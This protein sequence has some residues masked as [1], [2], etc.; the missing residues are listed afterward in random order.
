MTEKKKADTKKTTTKKVAPAK[1]TTATKKTETKKAEPKTTKPA[2]SK[3][4]V[5]DR[6]E[7]IACR[8][9]TD[10][11][12]IYISDRT[13]ARY[14]WS[15]FGVAQYIDMGELLD[16]RA[17]QPKFLNNVQLVVDDEEA[18]EY[19]GLTSLYESLVD[20][21]DLDS[22][23]KK[24][25]QELAEILP[26]LPLGIQQTVATHARKLIESNELSDLNTIRLLDRHLNV[27][28]SKFIKH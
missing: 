4:V 15:E 16:M 19:L 5:I 8:S 14:L 6:N 3:R 20:I 10:G 27:D 28:L 25:D 2:R 26:K 23:Y 9:V 11:T 7:M 13:R 17:S 18:A 22:F 21:D 24:S 1:K 12:L